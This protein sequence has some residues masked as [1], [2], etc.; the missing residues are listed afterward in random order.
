MSSVITFAANSDLFRKRKRVYRACESCKKRR[1]R[2]THTFD[3]EANPSFYEDGPS[4]KR[5]DTQDKSMNIDGQDRQNDHKS[6]SPHTVDDNN[7]RSDLVSQTRSRYSRSPSASPSRFVG[8]LHPEA[9]LEQ[10]AGSNQNECGY[11]MNRSSENKQNRHRGLQ[12]DEERALERYLFT[13]DVSVIPPKEHLDALLEIY[14]SSIHPVLPIVDS[15]RPGR[16][17]NGTLLSPMILQAICVIASRHDKARPHLVIYGNVR[18]EPRDFA[19]RLYRSVVAALNA[20]LETDRIVLIQALALLSLHVEGTDGAEKASMHLS[21]AIHHAHTLGMQFGK[22]R[23]DDRA[24]YFHSLFWCLWSLDKLN[25]TMLARPLLM[26]DRD[27]HLESPLL[28]PDLKHTPFGIW[29]Q[30]AALL[31]RITDFY[32]PTVDPSTTGWEEGFP[33]FEEVIGDSGETIEPPILVVLELF[34][35]CAAMCSHKAR[36]ITEP[37]PSSKSSYVRK[38]L[39]TVRVIQILA[40]E[41]PNNL[42]PLPVL[43]WALSLAVANAYRQLRQSRVP[44]HRSRAKLELQKCC[45]LLEKLRTNWWSAGRMADLGRAA[46]KKASK[47]SASVSGPGTQQERHTFTTAGTRRITSSLD[48]PASITNPGQQQ[49]SVDRETGTRRASNSLP[50]SIVSTPSADSVNLGFDPTV[51]PDWLNFDT[52][53]ENFDAVLGSSGA[54]LS[55]E[56]LRPFNFDDMGSQDFVG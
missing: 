22:A 54:D 1:K 19:Q 39:S 24:E 29:L 17:R 3:G 48:S 18:M 42:P 5:Q 40:E 46:L 10:A 50:K 4:P 35:N 34:Y 56:L 43:P 52:A 15:E 12:T 38:G 30:I 36:P 47:A 13:I 41:S 51:S 37:A 21:Q 14:F 2:C 8:N 53:F 7:T 55:M 26:H 49:P 25:A 28:N 33:G 6:N 31:D 44:T 16:R 27:N 45:E 20:N 23:G 9:I 11:W 32:R